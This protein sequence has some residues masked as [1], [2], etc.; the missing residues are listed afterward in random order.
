MSLHGSDT[1]AAPRHGLEPVAFP[2]DRGARFHQMLEPRDVDPHGALGSGLGIEAL[3][4]ELDEH[5]IPRRADDAKRAVLRL[6]I[7][8]A[9]GGFSGFSGVWTP[10]P[11]WGVAVTGPWSSLAPVVSMSSSQ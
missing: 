8:D 1:H 6:A 4:A 10:A 11:D 5:T 9:A 2:R 3:S 7:G